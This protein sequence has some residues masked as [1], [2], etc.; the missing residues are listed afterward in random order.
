[1]KN[2]HVVLSSGPPIEER[3]RQLAEVWLRD[4]RDRDQLLT[5]KAFFG[6]YSWYVSYSR[7]GAGLDTAS[8]EYVAASYDLI[9]G[10][11]GW[12]AMLRERAVC[13]SCQDTYRLENM[14]LCTGCMRYAC[15]AC[16]P[17]GSCAGEIV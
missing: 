7:H 17:H 2:N 9:G 15:Y 13:E 14:G 4:G 1:M 6:L 16:G 10:G 11:D 5:G 3:V 8:A 12:N